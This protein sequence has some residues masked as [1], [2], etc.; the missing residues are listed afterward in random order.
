M[1]ASQQGSQSQGQGGEKKWANESLRPITIK[2][3]IDCKEAYPKAELAVD[4]LPTTQVTLV[5]QIRSI[6]QQTVNVTYRIDDGTGIINVKKWIDADKADS[7]PSFALDTYV[8][9][10]GRLTTWDGR[11][12]VGAHYIRAIE[13]FNEVNYHLLEATYV[14]LALTRVAEGGEHQ[15]QGQMGA[16]DG[17][18]GMFVDDGYGG[19]GGG[20][21]GADS[22]TIRLRLGPCSRNANAIY[23]YLANSAGD[24]QHLNQVAAGTGISVRDILA[25]A[26]E[27]VNQGLIYTTENDETWAILDL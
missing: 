24:A 19:G 21:G 11:K 9:V 25:A 4:G 3:L 7:A 14:H 18:D 26:D 1:V 10:Y 15:Q 12:H 17:G 6:N 22:H 8:R 5:G 16:A 27:L 13:D 23:R 20:G 2:Q